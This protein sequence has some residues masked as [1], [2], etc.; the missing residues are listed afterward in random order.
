M[1]ANSEGCRLNGPMR[2]QR[3]APIC[4]TPF[5]EHEQEQQ[6]PE[7]DVE[8]QRV[9]AR[10]SGSRRPGR[11]AERR[12]GRRRA[13]RPGSRTC[14]PAWPPVRQRHVGGAVDHRDADAG[15]QQHRRRAAAS[16]CGSRAGVRTSRLH[17]PPPRPARRRAARQR[18]A[19]R[20]E[21]HVRAAS[22]P[23]AAACRPSWRSRCRARA[24]RSARRRRR[25]PPCSSEHDAGD[26]AGCRA[27]RRTRTSRCRG[28]PC[29]RSW[30][31][32][33][34]PAF[35]ITCA[36]PVLPET[37]CPSIRARPPVPA[38]LTTTHSPS[39]IGRELL[40]RDVHLRLRRRRRR[41]ASSPRRRPSP[42]PG[43][44]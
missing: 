34:L 31:R 22:A 19:G 12:A 13:R 25:G 16:R 44:A 4:V 32:A 17:G 23:A 33:A 41:P 42:S 27:A 30:P 18:I 3:C 20:L 43:A 28:S 15:E 8:E 10:A 5:N 37:S 6:R 39:R 35:E 7:R 21:P 9:L 1:R 40:G 11:R 26:L 24:A 14:G 38:P 36:V 29:R 2:I